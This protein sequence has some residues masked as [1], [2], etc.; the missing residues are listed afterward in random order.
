M[1]Q[2]IKTTSFIGLLVLVLHLN[3]A[4]GQ[5]TSIDNNRMSRDL[6]IME[7]ILAE[8]FKTELKTGDN[9][10]H[11]ISGS[12]FLIR[13]ESD[14]RGTYLPGYGVIFSIPSSQPF[15]AGLSGGDSKSFS[16][17]FRYGDGDD[18]ENI[19]EES[20]TNRIKE[21]LR[22]YG[23]TIGQLTGDD[24]VM[25]IYNA[26]DLSPRIAFFSSDEKEKQNKIPTISVV[27]RESDLQAYRSGKISA[28][29][30]NDR[31]DISKV[32]DGTDQKDLKIMA[33]IIET[34]FK[35]TGEKAFRV[36]GSVNYLKLDNFGALFSF[37]A[38]YS[39]G[40]VVFS[41]I[42]PLSEE[43]A[44]AVE[45]IRDKRVVKDKVKKE[46]DKTAKEFEEQEARQKQ[47]VLEAYKTFLGDLKEYLVDYGR[48]LK[49]VNTN[50]HIL[51][52]VTFSSRF[53]DI[54][55]R[56]DMQLQK[57][58]LEAMDKGKMNREQAMNQITVREY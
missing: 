36:S 52:S 29:T 3:H 4:V 5:Q 47:I 24:K 9:K 16:Y 14:I 50:Q 40:G 23:S 30:F 21:F 46:D 18:G 12:H 17:N 57:S 35:D 33:N 8:M 58:T 38:R 37:D 11:I 51:I 54:P 6:N 55:E 39:T 48:T 25:V 44:R 31:L 13:G 56:I 43:S 53:E 19:S 7:N 15:I 10:V 41:R 22:E 49:S 26:E 2:Y 20:I 42:A 28:E 27:A 32:E 1:N 45:V 34:A